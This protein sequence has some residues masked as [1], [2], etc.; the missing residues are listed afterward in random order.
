MV[1]AGTGSRERKIVRVA[2]LGLAPAAGLSIYLTSSSSG[3]IS[4]SL[5]LLFAAIGFIPPLLAGHPRIADTSCALAT[6]TAVGTA[7][8][9]EEAPQSYAIAVFA[10]FYGVVV[11]GLARQ[12]RIAAALTGTAESAPL[13][14]QPDIPPALPRKDVRTP[15]LIESVVQE[16]RSPANVILGFSEILHSPAAHD[17]DEAVLSS[18]RQFVLDNSR[19]LSNV[20]AELGDMIRLDC[21]RFRLIEQDI[22]AAELAE[23]A[24]RQCR[25]DAEKADVVIIAGLYDGIELHCDSIRIRQALASIVTR[26]VKTAPPRSAVKVAFSRTESD[27]LAISVTDRGRSLLME[28]RESLEVPDLGRNGLSALSLPIARRIVLLHSGSLTIDS[29]SGAGTTLRL[30]LPAGR[31]KWPSVQET[32]AMRAA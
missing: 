22:D 17:I 31:V 32:I 26:A 23:A 9:S 8:L 11:G 25:A 16:L 1:G 2:L 13:L 10:V 14:T 24:I 12:L 20:L 18:Y 30:V 15:D 7:L 4:L 27:G 5:L 3:D 29:A 21:G 19:S 28:D 6:F